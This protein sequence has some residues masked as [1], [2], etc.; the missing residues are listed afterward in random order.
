MIRK[1]KDKTKRRF[2][3][4]AIF[5]GIIAVVFI[6]RLFVMQIVDG[7]D[8]L[9]QAEQR[10][11]RSVNIKAPRG[12]ILDRYGRP[13]VTNKVGY[14]LHVQRTTLNNTEFNSILLRLYRLIESE[15]SEVLESFPITLYEP[16]EFTF[17]QRYP[18]EEKA[19]EEELK[20]K[21]DSIIKFGD[22][23][24]TLE[25]IERYRNRYKIS[26]DYSLEDQRR[27]IGMRYAME[28]IGSSV[29]SPY[30]VASDVNMSLVT[31]IKEERQ[32][33]P[34]VNV[35]N[36]YV[37]EYKQGS[38]AAHIL[39]RIATIS[40]K[41][42]EVKKALGYRLTDFIGK[43]GIEF[44]YEDAL[45][46]A[47]GYNSLVE[48]SEGFVAQPGVSKDPIPGD[49]VVLTIDSKLQA[50][51][52]DALGKTIDDIRMR[53]GDPSEKS[54]GDAYCGAAVVIDIHTGEILAMAT[55]PTFD[56]SE[57]SSK[58][59]EL[60]ADPNKPMWNRA[61]SGAYPPGSSFKMLVSIA[62]LET[63]IIDRNTVIKDEGVYTLYQGYQPACWLW[64][65]NQTTHGNQTVSTALANS[66][67]YFYYEV[68][69]ELGIDIINEYARKF[70]FGDYT[71]IELKSAETKSRIA[72]PEDR[73]R[74]GG[75]PW[76]GGDVLQASIGQ[77]DN[78]F[79]PLQLANYV[80][81]LV[82]GGIRYQPHIVKTVRSSVDSSNIADTVPTVLET[83]PMKP[84]N[85]EAV[86][87]G[88]LGVT[89]NGTAASAFNGYA[90]KVG[91]KT[92]SAQVDKGSDHGVFVGFAPYDNPEIA[93]AVVIEH[94]NSG[95]DLVPVVKAVFDAYFLAG[96]H[97]SDINKITG[98]LLP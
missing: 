81:T 40:P 91:G 25:V 98:V 13:L 60:S 1:Q 70:G 33:Y 92:G 39:G 50:T 95:S 53:G 29:T 3:A 89:E 94:G 36:D 32:D 48:T 78:L 82:N 59:N 10:Q 88:M 5:I 66:C 76:T 17:S 38:I 45:R 14:S 68:G 4:Y 67:N 11:I 43:D 15:G 54:G 9:K 79:T 19:R 84:E 42:Y 37:R 21:N 57:F 41:E 73:E 20:W 49:F 96:E 83:I 86:L 24:T 90:I 72:G 47:D 31:K 6:G 71:G 85:I 55:W 74:Y 44:E 87:E 8:Y 35:V 64:R 27:I 69:R 93:V 80:A 16:L 12:E 28:L 26:D 23:A 77:S 56:P 63:G 2:T 22:D 58:Y 30:V 97:Q 62:A 51:L 65:R 61:I 46:G 7:D 52:E 34:C 18:E 75:E